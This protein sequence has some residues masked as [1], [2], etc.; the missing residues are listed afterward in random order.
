MVRRRA[1][2]S[3]TMRPGWWLHPSRRLLRKLLRMRERAADDARYSGRLLEQFATDQHAADFAGAGADLVEFGVAKQPAG[4]I[5]VDITIA[6]EQLDRIE[7]ALGGL[8]RGIE[9]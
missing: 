3:R 8:L 6:A 1:A 2:P 7:R 9:D 4:R 5:V